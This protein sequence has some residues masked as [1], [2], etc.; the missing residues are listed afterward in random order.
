VRHDYRQNPFDWIVQP[1]KGFDE[2]ELDFLELY[3]TFFQ[4]KVAKKRK[5]L[6]R[7]SQ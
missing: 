2:G 1:E 7:I 4:E 6:L 3:A 5:R